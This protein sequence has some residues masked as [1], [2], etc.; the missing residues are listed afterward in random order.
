[1]DKKG[2]CHVLRHLGNYGLQQGW[3]KTSWH[4]M[5][6]A[7]PLFGD[8]P[9]SALSTHLLSGSQTFSIGG[10]FDILDHWPWFPIRPT[11]LL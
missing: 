8:V 1:M 5:Q 9:A 11:I 2:S 7:T 6:N 10:F 4:Q 3:P